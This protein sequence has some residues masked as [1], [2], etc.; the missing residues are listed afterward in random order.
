MRGI[1]VED[2]RDLDGTRTRD[3]QYPEPIPVLSGQ[4]YRSLQR[5]IPARSPSRDGAGV[6]EDPLRSLFPGP[7]HRIRTSHSPRIDGV[8]FV[9]VPQRTAPDRSGRL[10]VPPFDVSLLNPN[11]APFRTRS[12]GVPKDW[13]VHR[14]RKRPSDSHFAT[15]GSAHSSPVRAFHGAG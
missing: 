8:A 10:R 13:C 3:G 1:H 12:I 15:K 11:P 4:S 5:M 2:P 7:R 6:G 9:R 14:R